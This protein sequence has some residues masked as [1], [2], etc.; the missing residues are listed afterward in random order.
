GARAAQAGQDGGDPQCAGR[1]Q[2]DQRGQLVA[3]G[4]LEQVRHGQ[5]GDAG[6]QEGEGR[7]RGGTAGG[8]C[9]AAG[10]E[11]Q[12]GQGG[13]DRERVQRPGGV[14][15]AE[16]VAAQEVGQRLRD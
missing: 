12:P 8:G 14:A 7:R 5:H 6:G 13:E 4:E 1:G 2:G 10:A 11:D 3:P 16:L 9:A 15:A